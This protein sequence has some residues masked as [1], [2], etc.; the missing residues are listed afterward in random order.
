MILP[1][2]NLLLYAFRA[3]FPEHAATRRW[4]DGMLASR[5]GMIIHPLAGCAFLRLTTRPLGPLPPAP[6]SLAVAFL[7][8]LEHTCGGGALTEKPAHASVLA[9][10]CAE[11]RIAGDSIVDA[12]LA[13]SA[14]TLHITLASHDRG[15]KRFTPELDWLDPLPVPNEPT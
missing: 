7:G 13:A 2:T 4:L 15:F 14:I 8:A 11:H 3:E 6:L 1:D 5:Q 10:L 12:W 9:R